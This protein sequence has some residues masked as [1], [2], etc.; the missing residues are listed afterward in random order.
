MPSIENSPHNWNRIWGNTIFYLWG[1]RT[2][3]NIYRKLVYFSAFDRLL[4]SNSLADKEILELG[5]GT[6]DNSLYLA[7]QHYAG[8]VTLLD[9]SEQALAKVHAARYQFP[10]IK[11]QE[12]LFAFQPQK[13]Y[14]FVHSTGLI[15]HFEGDRRL[16]VVRKHA[17]C[18]RQGG[19]VMIWVPV[20][21]PLFSLLTRFN[22]LLGIEEIPFTERELKA[23]CIQSD[24]YIVNESRTAFG[25]LYGILARKA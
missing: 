11:V 19:F 23:L 12:D 1:F 17:E 15:E 24:L 5:S 16:A 18:T 4:D 3:G 21:T 20:R 8:S 9:F 10:V 7:Q 25:I 13:Q 2:V 6:G 22:R 14:D